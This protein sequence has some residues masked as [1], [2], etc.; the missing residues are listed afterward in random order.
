MQQKKHALNSATSAATR[1]AAHKMLITASAI[2]SSNCLQS[3]LFNSI[4]LINLIKQELPFLRGYFQNIKIG[5]IYN[6]KLW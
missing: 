1:G 6:K 2:P 5:R 4:Q 3:N